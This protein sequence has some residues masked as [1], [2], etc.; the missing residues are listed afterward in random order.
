MQNRDRMLQSA[1]RQM[2]VV[3]SRVSSR[4]RSSSLM[5]NHGQMLQSAAHQLSSVRNSLAASAGIVATGLRNLGQRLQTAV[6]NRSQSASAGA[7]NRNK[8]L[9]P[10]AP[11][12]SASASTVDTNPQELAARRADPKAAA[13]AKEEKEYQDPGR[14]RLR[15]VQGSDMTESHLSVEP[16]NNNAGRQSSN[17]SGEHALLLLG[18]LYCNF[19]L[20]LLDDAFLRAV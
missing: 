17:S 16:D 20:P 6:A 3:G 14:S 5:Q 4:V 11:A 10:P 9:P 18:G 7:A 2:S 13:S 12:A 15:K 1:S 19:L 8:M